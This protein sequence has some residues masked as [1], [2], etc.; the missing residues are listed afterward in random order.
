MLTFSRGKLKSAKVET[1]ADPVNSVVKSRRLEAY[2][3]PY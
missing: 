1:V 3:K 2:N